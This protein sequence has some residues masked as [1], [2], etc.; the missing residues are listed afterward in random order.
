[1]T[2]S[3]Q[4][5]HQTVWDLVD[6]AAC[7]VIDLDA[8][9]TNVRAV[10]ESR[11]PGTTVMAVVKAD[12]YG[13]GSEL[14]A[15]AAIE[16]GAAMLGVATLQEALKLRARQPAV[17]ILVLSPIEPMFAIK[18][19][20]HD[21]ALSI[22]DEQ[23]VAATM[24]AMSR[25]NNDRP[26]AI[27]LKLDTGMRRFGIEPREAVRMA[28]RLACSVGIRLEGVYTQFATADDPADDATDR[29]W[30][31]LRA[32]LTELR[33]AGHGQ[34]MAHA[35]NSAAILRSTDHD[36]DMVRLG[37]S[38]YGIPPSPHVPLLPSMRPAMSVKA[39][40]QRVVRSEEGDRVSYG[41]S[42]VTERGEWLGLV[43][44]GYADGIPRS[45]SNKGWLGGPG[46]ARLPIRGR[47]CMD[48]LVIGLG[49]GEAPLA[50]AGDEVMLLATDRS[51]GPTAV[52]VAELAGTIPYEICT[53]IALRLPRVYIRGGAIVAYND[54]RE[55]V[56]L[57]D[58]ERA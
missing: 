43:P 12:G 28:G 57:E 1:M 36:L 39:R 21:I 11:S 7:A 58:A 56:R 20:S 33:S 51:F 54:G 19:A 22:G 47:V 40:L 34:F 29:Q 26:L 10:S 31:L 45:L 18:A 27:H 42:Y 55:L 23:A 17:P 25:H 44:V 46:E 3:S 32:C 53:S 37:I 52:S 16:A 4:E 9:S 15:E 49:S 50:S 35:A 14:I 6:R 48:Q 24:E 41:G 5:A 38:L 2:T 8:I 13:H 30:R